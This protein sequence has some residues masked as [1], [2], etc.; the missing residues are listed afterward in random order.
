MAVHVQTEGD[1][2]SFFSEKNETFGNHVWV[3]SKNQD[4]I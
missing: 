2:L 1:I 3:Q 4:Y